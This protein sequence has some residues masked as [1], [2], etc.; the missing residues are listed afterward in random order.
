MITAFI[1]KTSCGSYHV[2]A[3]LAVEGQ[4]SLI[5]WPDSDTDFN[6]HTLNQKPYY[7]QVKP[8]LKIFL[9]ISST[10]PI[11]KLISNLLLKSDK[12]KS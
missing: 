9:L 6:T 3:K 11:L 10:N 8:K 4:F 2:H 12:L 7:Y 1:E 5:E